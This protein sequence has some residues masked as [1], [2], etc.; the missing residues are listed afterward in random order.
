MRAVAVPQLPQPDQCRG[1]CVYEPKWDGWRAAAFRIGDTVLLQSRSLRPL[2]KYFPDVAAHLSQLPAG[3]VLDG[4]LISFDP[5]AGRTSFTALRR[6]I[7]AGRG[8]AREAAARPVTYVC[9][10][11]LHDI[12]TDL[13][14][15]PLAQRRARLEATL[16]GAPTALQV[17]PQTS[18]Y[19]EALLWLDAYTPLGSEGL[20]IKDPAGTYRRTG[21]WKYKLRATAEAIIGGVVGTIEAPTS[22]LLGRYDRHRRLRFVGLAGV[23]TGAARR[24]L[25]PLLESLGRDGVSPW[26][27]PLP[28]GWLGQFNRPEPLAYVPVLP[29]LVAEIT[30]DQAYEAGRWRHQARYLRL[31]A[32]LRPYD[33]TPWS[34]DTPGSDSGAPS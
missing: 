23:L 17:C 22:L 14:N 32:D 15:L 21:W 24:E 3:T 5:D 26:P 6:R 19:D 16:A 18:S 34:I 25:A 29:L 9:F 13:R 11:Q 8:L 4:E 28:A 10:D 7:T 20:V 33:V 27:Q 12:D 30:V 2:A 31:R 1:G